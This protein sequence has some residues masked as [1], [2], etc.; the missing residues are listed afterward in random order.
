M[1]AKMKTT[2]LLI[3]TM[4]ACVSG[5]PRDIRDRHSP[6]TLHIQHDSEDGLVETSHEIGKRSPDD[7]IV[8]IHV[9]LDDDDDH[10]DDHYY[11][12]RKKR[13]PDHDDD[14]DDDDH[15]DDDHDDDDHDHDRKKR[16]PDHDDD[17]HDDDH[18]DDDHD[19]DRKKRS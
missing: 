5:L 12:D 15:D 6:Q 8:I 14:D 11:D 10:D 1:G 4:A 9:N 17:D 19:D 3:C 16:S 18:D 7:Q 13:S 2:I